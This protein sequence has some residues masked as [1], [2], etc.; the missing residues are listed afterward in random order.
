MHGNHKHRTNHTYITFFTKNIND[1]MP[2][3]C[4][5]SCIVLSVFSII[6]SCKEFRYIIYENMFQRQFDMD[7][8]VCFPLNKVVRSNTSQL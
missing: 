7:R 3:M 4:V 2:C 6:E 5:L 8:K 1:T